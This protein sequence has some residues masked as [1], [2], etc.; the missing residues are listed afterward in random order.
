MF[1]TLQLSRF[2]HC[3]TWN[4][5]TNVEEKVRSRSG[6]SSNVTLLRNIVARSSVVWMRKGVL[7]IAYCFRALPS[8]RETESNNANTCRAPG[9]WPRRKQAT[10]F[11]SVPR[12]EI[13]TKISRFGSEVNRGQWGQNQYSG[14]RLF[15]GYLSNTWYF[16]GC[17]KI[18][19]VLPID[20]VRVQRFLALSA[21]HE[22]MSGD[23]V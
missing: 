15:W 23:P 3:A 1:M 17:A 9:S 4:A 21:D 2:D 16:M 7:N 19:N 8:L 6:S 14:Y 20:A 10:S 22:W 5:E 11:F 12:T 13:W 18:G